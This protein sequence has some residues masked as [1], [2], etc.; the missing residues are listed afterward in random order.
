MAQGALH[1]FN[2]P[3]KLHGCSKQRK[4]QNSTST[5]TERSLLRYKEGLPLLKKKKKMVGGREE[6]KEKR[7][8]Y[9]SLKKI[10]FNV[11]YFCKA[12][13]EFVKILLLFY[14]FVF[15][16]MKHVGS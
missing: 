5:P 6:E 14:V 13:I 7:K 11:N 1:V 8:H 2:K 10:F 9:N 15:L 12:F 3:K 16:A 4:A